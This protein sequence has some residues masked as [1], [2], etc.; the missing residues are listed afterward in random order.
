MS[1]L[2]YPF[3]AAVAA[4]LFLPGLGA[5]DLWNPNEPLYA[6]AVAGMADASR[7]WWPSVNGVPFSE[8]P[9]LYF[10]LA[11][12]AASLVGS[13]D[14]AVLRLPAAV[15]GILLVVG[16]A[17]LVRPYRGARSAALAAAAVATTFVVFWSSRQIQ[18]D[19]PLAAATVWALVAATRAIDRRG[20]G[21]WCWLA[22]GLAC[23]V[24]ALFKGPVGLLCPAAI[25]GAYLAVTG[26]PFRHLRGA[27][28]WGGA[29]VVATAGPFFVGAAI[30][31]PPEA[32]EELLYRQ[33]VERF[34][35]PWDHRGPW[36]YYLAYL[37]IDMLP[38]VWLLPAS[39]GLQEKNKSTKRLQRLAWCWLIVPLLFFSLSQS[40]RS[41]YILP[42]APA[43]ACLAVSALEA[44]AAGRLGRGRRVLVLAALGA[45]PVAL[46]GLAAGL[47]WLAP[48]HQ[49]TLPGLA[50]AGRSL[51]AVA[52]VAAVTVA[53][54]LAAR[55][56]EGRQ[57][58]VASLAFAVV[59]LVG[60][61]AVLPRV[62][63][64]KSHRPF[65][66]RLRE[67]VGELPLRGFHEWR[68]R[69]DFTFY[70]RRSIPVMRDPEELRRYWANPGPVYLIVERGLLAEAR[71]VIGDVAWIDR[72]RAGHNEA[73]LFRSDPE[74]Q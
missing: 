46:A 7:F 40:K 18:M 43:V 60:A 57:G 29:G 34:L 55:G 9:L 35:D 2:F 32:L 66:E 36:W 28:V 50:A 63:P 51:A 53:A 8:K 12:A 21:R 67:H 71:A 6:A 11:R 16:T 44:W 1:R 42:V 4:L 10:W 52:F 5:R 69:S 65:A 20:S 74:G 47:V 24:G 72:H 37:W 22:F 3:C 26:R 39:I 23:G 70:A 56:R 64:L 38:W 45:Q 31:G 58:A 54:S 15:S 27:L 62:D 13:L 68:F 19:V 14:E 49:A 73:F 59:L 30:W 61:R 48:E 17:A 25:A 33:N 41:P